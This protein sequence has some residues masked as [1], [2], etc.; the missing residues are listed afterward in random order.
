MDLIDKK[1]VSCVQVAEDGGEI[2]GPFNGGT[3]GDAD[4]L[5]H[6]RRND[7]GQGG[8]AQTGGAVKQHMIQRVVPGKG[9]L[10]IDIEAFFDGL[11]AYIIPE[12]MGAESLLH[13][14]VLCHIGS[15]HQSVIHHNL[16]L[17]VSV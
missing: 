7:A 15:G 4:V 11:L 9:S 3:A 17:P 16:L 13:R 14:A 1:H 10:D 5:T 2:A 6:L 12:G 8:F